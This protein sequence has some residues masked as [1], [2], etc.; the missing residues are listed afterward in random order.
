MISS[1]ST[2]LD[3]WQPVML[4]DSCIVVR[5]TQQTELLFDLAIYCNLFTRQ[6]RG[7]G[8]ISCLAITVQQ[9]ESP[10]KS[11]SAFSLIQF[12]SESCWISEPHTVEPKGF[13][14]LHK[15]VVCSYSVVLCSTASIHWASLLLTWSQLDQLRQKVTIF[16]FS[17]NQT[18]QI[19]KTN[20]N[21]IIELFELVFPIKI[22]LRYNFNLSRSALTVLGDWA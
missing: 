6:C 20:S 11:R 7:I 5:E 9:F 4:E 10:C 2:L 21:L 3:C 14:R 19:K 12:L 22:K 18:I 1:R 8:A 13:N 17:I 16:L 15:F